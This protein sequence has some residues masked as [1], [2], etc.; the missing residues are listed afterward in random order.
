MMGE[1]DPSAL[2]L[3][4]EDAC[5]LAAAWVGAL[6]E[7]HTFRLLVIKGQT[8]AHHG[9]RPPRTSADVDILVDPQQF[10]DFCVAVRMAGWRQRPV[11]E[12]GAMWAGHSLTFVNDTWPCDIDVHRYFPGF[13]ADPSKTFDLLWRSRDSMLIANRLVPIPSR[14]ASILISGLHQLRDGDTRADEAEMASVT[15]VE[16]SD[17]ERP[18]IVELAKA[19][20]ALEPARDLLLRLGIHADELPPFRDSAAVREWHARAA[21]NASGVFFWM[22]LLERTP[23]GGRLGVLGRALWP[24]REVLMIDHPGL[25]DTILNRTMLRLSRLPGGLRGIGPAA[26]AIWDR[27]R[28]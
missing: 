13:L 20:E 7:Q 25:S 9:L 1:A 8:L 28:P 27:H 11:T 16:I 15:S 4:L 17:D 23:A 14:L 21:A 12:V 19:T 26:R 3:E 5:A 18:A 10:D 24:P 22:I 6:G 2:T